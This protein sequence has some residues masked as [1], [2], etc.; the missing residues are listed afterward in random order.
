MYCKST[1]GI[2]LCV[3]KIVAHIQRTVT[4]STIITTLNV[5]VSEDAANTLVVP[6]HDLTIV[7]TNPER[8]KDEN[9]K[10]VPVRSTS[11]RHKPAGGVRSGR[12]AERKP[13][14]GNRR[15]RRGE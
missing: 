13:G 5:S 1:T 15:S 4:I 14:L 6:P 8:E 9:I 11:A 3:K 2:S 12:R 7:V 10:A